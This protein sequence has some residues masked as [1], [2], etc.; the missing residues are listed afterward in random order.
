M[1]QNED[2]FEG[3]YE[4]GLPHGRGSYTWKQGFVF[5][6]IFEDGLRSGPGIIRRNDGYE[7]KGQY[8]DG[9]ANGPAVIIYPNGDCYRGNLVNGKRSGRGVWTEV[10]KKKTVDGVW[11]EDEIVETFTQPGSQAE[12]EAVDK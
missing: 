10:A 3:L 7:F 5:E 11:K 2:F 12:E 9:K 6:G 1:F 8:K 4:N